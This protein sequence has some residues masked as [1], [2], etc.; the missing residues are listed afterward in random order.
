MVESSLNVFA[1]AKQIGFEIIASAK[2]GPWL[3]TAQGYFIGG[4]IREILDGVI[5][6]DRVFPLLICNSK[7]LLFVPDQ[8]SAQLPLPL[9][10]GEMVWLLVIR[11]AGRASLVFGGLTL[12][13]HSY[14]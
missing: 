14:L 4:D 6:E 8:R 2:V 13:G 12:G 5:G 3:L 7:L 1:G 9:I 11:D 10:Q